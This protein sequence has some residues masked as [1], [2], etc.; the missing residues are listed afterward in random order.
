MNKYATTLVV[1]L[2]AAIVFAQSPVRISSPGLTGMNSNNDVDELKQTDSRKLVNTNISEHPGRIEKRKGFRVLAEVGYELDYAFG[3]FNQS[4]KRKLM[5]AYIYYDIDQTLF[6]YRERSYGGGEWTWGN[7]VVYTILS[8]T[9]IARFVHSGQND[10]VLDTTQ[11]VNTGLRGSYNY[12]KHFTGNQNKEIQ[13]FDDGVI[14]V[15][16][17]SEPRFVYTETGTEATDSMKDVSE[18]NPRM[19]PMALPAPG[20]PIVSILSEPNGTVDG[21]VEYAYCYTDN[22]TGGDIDRSDTS[23]HSIIVRAQNQKVLVTGFLPRPYSVSD[24]TEFGVLP[25]TR[26][27][28]FRR[29]LHNTNSLSNWSRVGIFW[30]DHHH[31]PMVIDSGQFQGQTLATLIID[32]TISIPGTIRESYIDTTTIS[33]LTAD[34]ESIV[35][36]NDSI[37]YL[38]WSWYDPILDIESPLSPPSAVKLTYLETSPTPDTV[39]TKVFTMGFIPDSRAIAR[40]M[41]IYQTVVDDGEIGGSDTAIYYGVLQIKVDINRE[42]PVVDPKGNTF[43]LGFMYDTSITAGTN[44]EDNV[45]ASDS[46]GY[47]NENNIKDENG[48]IVL[49]PPFIFGNQIPYSDILFSN[50]RFWGIGDPLF[51]SRLYYS[52]YNKMSNWSLASDYLDLET[53]IND[54][55]VALEAGSTDDILYCFMRNSVWGIGGY[56]VEYDLTLQRI[57]EKGAASRRSV[58]NL[59]GLILF[60]TPSG[61]IR[62]LAENLPEISFGVSNWVDSL[63]STFNIAKNQSFSYRTQDDLYFGNDDSTYC[64]KYNVDSKT[65]SITDYASGFTPNHSFIYDTV[66]GRFGHGEESWNLLID[67]SE[68]IFEIKDRFVDSTGSADSIYQFIYQT[69]FVGDGNWMY[70]IQEV[71]FTGVWSG[72]MQM[73]VLNSNGDTLATTT[74]TSANDSIQTYRVGLPIHES[75]Y[76]SVEFSGSTVVSGEAWIGSISLYPVKVRQN[77]TK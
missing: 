3:I 1:L 74:L 2:L 7:D 22:V 59:D 15:N 48:E 57:G 28:V 10:M 42:S 17:F 11:P 75:D 71:G 53:S 5:G 47:T 70:R 44:F 50:G 66:S 27:W 68:K 65:W 9:G 23:Y 25:P 67:N 58:T 49:I 76:L 4:E 62:Q 64:L 52:E 26:I 46:I 24:T 32:T 36:H 69:P 37:Y 43:W 73:N 35:P 51:P 40:Y 33:G 13:E 14:I 63:F 56:D 77:V 61:K 21:L 34:M 30:M 39:Y 41:R 20:Q 29:Y 72:A 16:G 12:L 54:E 45:Y 55:T 6:Q 8:D 38:R 60:L 18:Y 19:T 31:S